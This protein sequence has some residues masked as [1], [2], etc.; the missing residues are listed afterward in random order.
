MAGFS[1]NRFLEHSEKRP[2]G[3]GGPTA[4]E[5]NAEEMK[6]ALW[7]LELELEWE[8]AASGPRYWNSNPEFKLRAVSGRAEDG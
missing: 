6:E 5:E 7:P 8:L 4:T 2:V 3:D 1:C